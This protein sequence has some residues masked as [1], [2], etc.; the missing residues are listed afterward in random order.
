M[1]DSAITEVA[2]Q[3]AHRALLVQ[4][5][6]QAAEP[7]WYLHK[8]AELDWQEMGGKLKE[9][10]L[11][12]DNPWQKA[13][14]GAG[15]G[16][17][18]GLGSSLFQKEEERQPGRSLITGALAGG[19]LGGGAGLAQKYLKNPWAKSPE[20]VLPESKNWNDINRMAQQDAP[21]EELAAAV[22]AQDPGYFANVLPGTDLPPGLESPALNAA[23]APPGGQWWPYVG[24]VGLTH[25][26]A[27]IPGDLRNLHQSGLDAAVER[28]LSGRLLPTAR[29]AHPGLDRRVGATIRRGAGNIPSLTGDHAEGWGRLANEL[30]DPELGRRFRLMSPRQST[31]AAAQAALARP[32]GEAGKQRVGHPLLA[33]P[34]QSRWRSLRATLSELPEME[35]RPAWNAQRVIQ[36]AGL[37]YLQQVP[38]VGAFKN[39]PVL[40][41]YLSQIDKIQTQ[42]QAMGPGDFTDINPHTNASRQAR[43]AMDSLARLRELAEARRAQLTT[44]ETRLIP[45]HSLAQAGRAGLEGLAETPPSAFFRRARFWAPATLATAAAESWLKARLIA[46]RN[47]HLTEQL[48]AA[49]RAKGYKF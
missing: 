12:R 30:T 20:S 37:P 41:R 24:G 16:G 44:S 15:A 38:D 33:Q 13:L 6:P 22:K 10:L 48:N 17:L 2:Q 39:D 14:A 47:K 46:Q 45:R 7:G 1:P 23:Y 32:F 8:Q 26:L 35:R 5:F 4:R 21:P 31:L 28:S 42:L 40:Q 9:W 3:L 25:S 27:G 36:R 43:A 29:W 49:L 18:L 11:R 19:L 34:P